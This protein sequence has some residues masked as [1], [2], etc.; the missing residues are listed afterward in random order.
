[1]LVEALGWRCE[2]RRLEMLE[3]WNVR[4]PR[5]RPS[6]AHVD[7][8]RS[9]PLEPPWPDLILTV[10]RRPSMAA[11]WVREQSRGRTRIVLLGKPSGRL[12]DFDLVI[13]SGEVQM[14]ARPNVLKLQLPLMRVPAAAVDAARERWRPKL[15]DLPRPLIAVLVGGPTNPFVYKASVVTRLVEL[16]RSIVEELGG[17]AY[18]TT[19]RRTPPA[20]VAALEARLVSGAWLFQWDP[21]S[22]ENPYLGLLGLAD[23]FV[24]TADSLSM[25]VEVA[26]LRRPL[27]IFPLPLGLRGGIDQRRRAL[28]RWLFAPAGESAG[29]RVREALGRALHRAR[30]FGH[31]RDF[32]AV[33]D[34]LLQRGLATRVGEGFEPPRGELPDDL[35]LAVARIRRLLER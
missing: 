17:T 5:Y 18:L 28:A 30:L 23:G 35:A 13:L 27:A 8:A 9:D 21:G 24:V 14:P 3:P 33:H 26:G 29:S 1:M 20:I 4:K 11:L 16:E 2:V 32:T 19:S 15:A 22:S 25:M 7:L 34:L 31:T 10:G 12:D 6:L